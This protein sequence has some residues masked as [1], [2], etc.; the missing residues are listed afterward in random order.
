MA[1]SVTSV[2]TPT[3]ENGFIGSGDTVT[4]ASFTVSGTNKALFVCMM[5]WQDVPGSG[6]IS[7]ITWNTS[8]SLTKIVEKTVTAGAMRAEIWRLINPT[9]ATAN[10]VA[11]ISGDTDARKM[12]AI[13]FDGADQTDPDE[14][15]QTSEGGAGPITLD[16]TTLTDGA[17]VVDC[18]S[19]FTTD[20]ITIGADQTPIMDDQTGSTGGVASYESKATAGTVTMSWTKTGSDDWAQ[21]ALSV[22]P[23]AAT[24]IVK[25]PIGPGIEVFPR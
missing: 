17:I 12:G 23:A 19:N 4:I 21:V 1:L 9:N 2:A 10:I 8:Q 6:T 3:I 5:L 25:D 15:T 13:L 11:T 20:A 7:G 22:K 24:T 18:G 14:A 16:I